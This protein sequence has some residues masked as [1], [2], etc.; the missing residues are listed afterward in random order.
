MAAELHVVHLK[1]RH[2][3]AR[4]TSPAVT[5]QDLLAQVF[6]RQRTEPQGSGFGVNHSQDAFSRRFSRE[7]CRC[8][9]GKNL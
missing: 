5:S 2:R 1:I 6:V 7:A 3:S 4:L 9:L 8:S